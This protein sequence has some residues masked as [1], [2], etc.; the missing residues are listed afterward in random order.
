MI[1]FVK[2][3]ITIEFPTT[4]LRSLGLKILRKIYKIRKKSKTNLSSFLVCPECHNFLN[5]KNDDFI[6]EYCK[7]KFSK[8]PIP[9]FTKSSPLE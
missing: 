6:C 9:D 5:E 3:E 4:D 7:V 1:F 2:G 8:K